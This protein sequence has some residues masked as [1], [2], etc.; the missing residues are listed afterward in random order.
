MFYYTELPT[1][2]INLSIHEEHLSYN[3]PPSVKF[4]LT[5]QFSG[6]ILIRFV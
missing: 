2:T 3:F 4:K 1:T 6:V 5:T